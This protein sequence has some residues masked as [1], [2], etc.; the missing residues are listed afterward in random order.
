MK[1]C[2]ATD[3]HLSYKQYGL[4]AREQDFYNQYESLINRIIEEKPKAFLILGDIFDTP[5]PKPISIKKFEEGLAKLKEHDIGTY[6]IIG[7]HTLIQRK[8]YYPIDRIFEDK[9]HL[10]NEDGIVIDGVFIGGLNYHPKNHDIKP[11]IDR[12]YEKAKGCTVKILML[13]QILKQ[14][15]SIGYDYDED[16]LG[17]DRFDYVFLGHLHKRVTR[18]KGNTVIHY[19]GSLNSCNVTELIDEMN[20][21]KGY[22]VL[23]TDS[24]EM[25]YESLLPQ[26]QYV[27]Y[28]LKNNELNDKFIDDSIESLKGYDVKPIVMLE[29]IG[30]NA[31]D[32][33]EFRKKL[34]DVSLIVKQNIREHEQEKIS[35]D[36]DIAVG[37][38]GV[39]KM[40]EDS[41]DEK[42]KGDLAIALFRAL[43]EGDV[44]GALE[45]SNEVYNE[46]FI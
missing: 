25:Y 16:D 17:L 10:L 36:A 45:I 24:S 15:Q 21:G 28:N 37:M 9:Y 26:R 11:L 44:E 35:L 40:I 14:D 18:H 41:Y 43:K 3:F 13:H 46:T 32:I 8:N 12:I 42:W 1:I 6:G 19:T 33:Y 29:T 4:E 20:Y 31:N 2:I 23:D 30:N 7:N 5:Y 38:M 39:E 27:H 34:E 22:T